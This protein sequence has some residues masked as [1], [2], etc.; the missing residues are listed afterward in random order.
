[1]KRDDPN[2]L[3]TISLSLPSAFIPP[4]RGQKS[5]ETLLS[6]FF[7]LLSL[8]IFLRSSVPRPPLGEFGCPFSLTPIQRRP[9]LHLFSTSIIRLLSTPACRTRSRTTGC[10][11]RTSPAAPSATSA[12]PSCT[13]SATR[14]SSA[15][16]QSTASSGGDLFSSLNLQYEYVHFSFCLQL[17]KF[18]YSIQ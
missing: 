9:T 16:V 13:D 2:P 14:D 7:Q 1:M 10:S 5:V 15:R 17:R 11:T 12:E 3:S 8:L 18:H 4:L 6:P